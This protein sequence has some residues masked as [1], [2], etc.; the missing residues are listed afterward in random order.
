MTSEPSTA[1][2]IDAL[3][4]DLLVGWDVYSTAIVTAIVAY[5]GYILFFSQDADAHPYMLAYQAV[6]SRIRQRGESA[7]FRAHEVPH[8]YPLK[9]G[10]GVKDPGTPK[11]T[12]GRKGD[13]RD[14]WRSAV[15]G[16]YDEGTKAQKRGAIYRV[17]GKNMVESSVDDISREVNILGQYIRD[18]KPQTVGVCLSDSV[19][20]L[21]TIFGKRRL[22]HQTDTLCRTIDN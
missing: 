16:V 18:S 22:N 13:L 3:L 6:A 12:T 2:K 1:A 20:L 4:A 10:L 21:A 19:E 15:N 11:W 8:G 17:Q 9:S 5:L 7:A 14:I